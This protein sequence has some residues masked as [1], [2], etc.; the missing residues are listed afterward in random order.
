MPRKAK[1]QL[2]GLKTKNGSTKLTSCQEKQNG[3][4][5]VKQIQVQLLK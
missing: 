4:L 2:N 5:T 1:R 3:N